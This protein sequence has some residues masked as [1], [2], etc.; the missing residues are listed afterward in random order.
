MGDASRTSLRASELVRRRHPFGVE[1]LPP[2]AATLDTMYRAC[3][4][5]GSGVQRPGCE[6]Q[7][8]SELALRASDF[9]IGSKPDRRCVTAPTTKWAA[10]NQGSLGAGAMGE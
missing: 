6:G 1:R 7:P 2:P 10:V 5:H 4:G 3:T 8:W 9:C